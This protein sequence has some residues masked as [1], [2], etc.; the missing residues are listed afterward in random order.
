MNYRCFG[1]A[2]A[3]LLS[4]IICLDQKG[5]AE[6]RPPNIL[7]IVADDLGWNDVGYHNPEMR[8]PNLDRLARHSVEFDCHYVQPECTPTRV[9]LL[10]GRYPSRFGPNAM[11]ASNERAIP[12]G[13]LTMPSMLKSL[14]YTTGMAG[15]WHLG[16]RPEYGPNHYGFDS[17]Y[18]SLAGAV[19]V[20]DHR[21][22]LKSPFSETWH[23][24]ERIIEGYENG[25]HV[26][27]LV[28]RETVRW[29]KKDAKE[30]WFF[31]VPFHAVHVPL[32]ERDKKWH[33]IN[34]HI[35]SPDRCL[36][37]AA[38]SHMD[39]AV[40]QMIDVLREQGQLDETLVLF[41]SDNGAQVNHSGGAYPDPDPKLSDF[42]SNSPL[43]GKKAQ[44][45]EGGYRVPAFLYWPQEL[46][47]RKVTMPMH[48]VDWMPTFAS[49]LGY[50]TGADPQWDGLDVW[51]V[52]TGE[53]ETLGQRTFYLTW[54]PNR[55]W[56]AL[57][58]GDWKIV[59]RNGGTWELFN[60]QQDPYERNDL[61]KQQPK[62]LDELVQSFDQ[63]RAKDPN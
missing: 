24:N 45:Y 31:Y 8:T 34:R 49:L 12:I 48:V 26:T 53:R 35:K 6:S 28:V 38:V 13:T 37:A 32:V 50:K 52:I 60:L 46:E 41:F 30:P 10:T 20:Y 42:S 25:T 43:R 22:R 21:Y 56:E 33:D 57:R 40:G 58:L 27:D 15:K 63:E 11:K 2:I 1:F 5:M 9:A 17:S 39:C 19:G 16:S 14:G 4:V 3:T 55:R 47:A 7:L 51:P 62:I 36:Y 18:G 54:H 23:R 44:L 59:R 61:A 29:I